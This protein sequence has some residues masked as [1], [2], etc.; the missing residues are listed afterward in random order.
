MAA[1]VTCSR[2]GWLPHEACPRWRQSTRWKQLDDSRG[3]RFL[4]ATQPSTNSSSYSRVAHLTARP[5]AHLLHSSPP[6]VTGTITQL[7]LSRGVGTLLGEDGKRYTFRRNDVREV[8]FHD[9]TEG[10]RVAFEPAKNLS[11]TQVRP[12]SASV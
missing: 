5:N 7:H 9:L 10:A 3:Q 1:R 4:R 6:S 8:W 11:A 2:P 12:V